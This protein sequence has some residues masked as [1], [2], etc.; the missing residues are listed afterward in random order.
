MNVTISVA[1]YGKND[2]GGVVVG[3]RNGH[4]H[5]DAIVAGIGDVD[6]T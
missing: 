1:T 5:P 4:Y 6:E 3:G 2:G